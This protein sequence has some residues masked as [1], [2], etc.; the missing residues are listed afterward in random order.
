MKNRIFRFFNAALLFSALSISAHANE[1]I[2]KITNHVVLGFYLDLCECELKDSDIR[3]VVS[4]LNVHPEIDSLN[5]GYNKQLTDEAA[6]LISKVPTITRQLLLSNDNVTDIGAEAIGKNAVAK[7]INLSTKPGSLNKITSKGAYYLAKNPYIEMLKISNNE[8][9]DDGAKFFGQSIK[10]KDLLVDN[11]NIGD[12]GAT[13]LATHKFNYLYLADNHIGN[14]GAKALAKADLYQ[15][16]FSNNPIG[17]P[18]IQALAK[19]ATLKGLALTHATHDGIS[20][21]AKSTSLDNLFITYSDMTDQDAKLFAAWPHNPGAFGGS[22]DFSHNHI[23]DEGAKALA[24]NSKLGQVV[25]SYNDIRNDGAFEF[26]KNTK[27]D[28]LNI[29]YNHIGPAG[30]EALL[31]SSIKHVDTFGNDGNQTSHQH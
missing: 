2:D 12:D 9:G 17:T 8:I 30:V 4:F 5:L 7:W 14:E 24:N 26:A 21:L 16:D 3:A 19:S 27:M 18:G 31:H 25:I 20:A 11:N 1:C 22:L 23:G 10:L 28:M 6:S 29:S 15:T 13:G